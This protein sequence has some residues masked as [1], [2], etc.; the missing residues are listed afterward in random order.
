MT[1][2]RD[3]CAPCDVAMF[4]DLGTCQPLT[5]AAHTPVSQDRLDALTVRA[6]D[7]FALA[8]IA[9]PD[10]QTVI[11]FDAQCNQICVRHGS[12]GTDLTC[13]QNPASGRYGL[14][15]IL[16]ETRIAA[17]DLDGADQ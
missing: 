9:V 1:A 17:R 4:A 2:L 16:S 10:A 3:R 12:E 5:S 11:L 8:G 14:I 15:D 13:V 7:G 6:S